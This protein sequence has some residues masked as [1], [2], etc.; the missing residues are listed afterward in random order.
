M[1]KRKH[2]V[3]DYIDI[4][5]SEASSSEYSEDLGPDYTEWE[6]V[7]SDKK[8]LSEE[9]SYS[10]S[11]PESIESQ[12]KQ[13]DRPINYLPNI[14]SP[15]LFLIR[16]PPGKEY[17]Y[18]LRI[19]T[20]KNV[21]SVIYKEELKGYLYVEA[22]NKRALQEN[23]KSRHVSLIPQSEMTDVFFYK[24]SFEKYGRIKSGKYKGDIC[25]ILSKINDEIIKF[26]LV[27]RIEGKRELF[28]STKYSFVKSHGYMIYKKDSYKNGFLEKEVLAR[29]VIPVSKIPLEDLEMFEPKKLL[30]NSQKVKIIKGEFKNEEGMVLRM[31]ADGVL[32]DLKNFGRQFLDFNMVQPIEEKELDFSVFKEERK[33]NEKDFLRKRRDPLINKEVTI[34][35]GQYKGYKGIITSTY[36]EKIKVLISSNN[37]EINLDREDIIVDEEMAPKFSQ[38]EFVETGFK[39]PGAEFRTPSY[40][41][42]GAEFRTPN[43][44]TPGL[45]FK[46]PGYKTPG[47][48][49][50]G[51]KTPGLEFKTPSYR[52]PGMDYSMKS[53]TKLETQPKKENISTSGLFKD[54]LIQVDN[55]I[56]EIIDSTNDEFICSDGKYKKSQVK[57]V[58]PEKYDTV[59]FMV[60]ENKGQHGLLVAITGDDCVVRLHEKPINCKINEISRVANK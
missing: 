53:N 42:P 9:E 14:Y 50:P 34:K 15:K 18:F 12:P 25:E 20:L 21:L 33:K 56:K 17:V 26:R 47:Y 30:K 51:Y 3:L 48:K 23:L 2:K 13:R 57:Y 28:D 59:C 35:K 58:S 36:R 19:S 49:T 45:E 10:E 11:Q 16:V 54:V 31:E 22:I 44:K 29:N 46:T 5:A 41:T 6:D 55:K 43:L 52:T 32:V 24:T 7:G 4:E 27:P 60:G 1:G 37:I 40:K 8:S 39:T 38:R